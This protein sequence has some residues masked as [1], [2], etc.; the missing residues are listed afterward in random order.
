MTEE[1]KLRVVNEERYADF[2]AIGH[3]GMGVVYLALDTELNRR[4]ALKVVRPEQSGEPETTSPLTLAPPR[5]DT[6]ASISF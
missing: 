3:G 4:V 1:R 6:P 2:S 5:D